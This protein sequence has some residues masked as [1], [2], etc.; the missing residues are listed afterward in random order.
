MPLTRNFMN[1][2][3]KQV[4][5]DLAYGETLRNKGIDVIPHV[6]STASKAIVPILKGI[7]GCPHGNH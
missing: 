7:E 4:A 1:L 6:G 2:A 3:Q 5:R